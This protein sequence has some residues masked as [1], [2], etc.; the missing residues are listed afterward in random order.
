MFVLLL[1]VSIVAGEMNLH[2]DKTSGIRGQ[3]L[4]SIHNHH[5]TKVSSDKTIL[6][7]IQ[8]I[9]RQCVVENG[10]HSNLYTV[11]N[12]VLLEKSIPIN[13]S[14]DRRLVSSEPC[15][16]CSPKE[17][18][19]TFVWKNGTAIFTTFGK[20]PVDRGT[21]TFG[22]FKGP[23][24]LDV[25][26]ALEEYHVKISINAENG[27]GYCRNNSTMIYF[28]N[29]TVLYKE[30][31]VEPEF[32]CVCNGIETSITATFDGDPEFFAWYFA[33]VG[34]IVLILVCSLTFL[35]CKC[36]PKTVTPEQE[37]ISLE[38]IP[39]DE[40]VETVVVNGRTLNIDSRGYVIVDR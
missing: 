29:S 8:Q 4:D 31:S 20:Y 17:T 22:E 39:L 14:Q 9:E 23:C 40:I 19:E 13:F 37:E 12:Y 34:A 1:L 24:N 33:I 5:C 10:C 26:L 11:I 36:E 18:G 25:K 32:D 3:Y 28:G 7:Q 6:T 38:E 21:L 27:V 35:Y 30:G 15:S 2:C 16:T